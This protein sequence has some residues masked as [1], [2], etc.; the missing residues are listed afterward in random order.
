MKPAGCPVGFFI[1]GIFFLS[2]YFKTE[3]SYDNF[4]FNQGGM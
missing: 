3:N 1:P 4:R 2:L